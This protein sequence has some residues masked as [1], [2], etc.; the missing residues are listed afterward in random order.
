MTLSE[1]QQ[2]AMTTCTRSSRNFTYMMLNF[3]GEL[4]E[5]AS[6]VAKAIRKEKVQVTQ[7]NL[8]LNSENSLS[9]DEIRDLKSEVGDCLW[10]LSGLCSVMGWS[11]EEIAQG[12]L[13]KLQS[14]QERGVIVGNGD[15]R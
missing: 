15:N 8:I 2:K 3:V 11:L 5:L 9:S 1:Y 10:Q 4:G 14:R 6:K 7:N 13:G 12:N